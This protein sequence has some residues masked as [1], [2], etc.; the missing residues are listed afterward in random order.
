MTVATEPS[1][2]AAL[3]SELGVK[4]VSVNKQLPALRTWLATHIAS[5]PLRISLCSNGYGLLLKESSAAHN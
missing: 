5:Q 1:S 3:L 4:Q 2:L